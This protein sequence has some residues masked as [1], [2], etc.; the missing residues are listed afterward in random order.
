MWWISCMPLSCSSCVFLA[1]LIR[2]PSL[3]LMNAPSLFLMRAPCL[4]LMHVPCLSLMHAPCLSLMHAPWVSGTS[5]SWQ[6][7]SYFLCCCDELPFPRR[8]EF[9]AVIP[10]N[11]PSAP[12]FPFCLSILYVKRLLLWCL[13]INPTGFFVP[14]LSFGTLQPCPEVNCVRT[15]LE[16][17]FGT[18]LT[19]GFT[20]EPGIRIWDKVWCSQLSLAPSK[21]F[22]WLMFCHLSFSG[23]Y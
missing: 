13:S 6:C 3:Y 2:V 14:F 10:L 7:I 12:P 8:A 23:L 9:S 11:N 16:T 1:Y 18:R 17:W 19:L 5:R 20:G 21:W 4:S 15:G 22:F